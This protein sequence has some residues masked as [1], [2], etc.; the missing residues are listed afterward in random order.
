M[1]SKSDELSQNVSSL[2][3]IGPKTRDL[4]NQLGIYSIFDLLTTIPNSLSDKREAEL[5]SQ[6]D[7]GDNVVLSGE[8]INTSRTKGYKPNYIL[9]VRSDTGIFN[10]RFI[11]KIVVF[12]NLQVGMS[13][14]IEGKAIKKSTKLEFIHPEIEII[15]TNKSLA[16]ILPKYSTKGKISQ[17][18][19]R[20]AIHEAFIRLSKNYEFTCLDILFN[21]DFNFMS[22]L[23]AVKKLH[24]PDGDFDDADGAPI[25]AL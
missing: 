5:L 11:H 18:K 15:Q 1:R 19:M 3:G 8:I 12:L 13:I 20:K 21:N 9:T 6:I 4:F 22:L 24:Y 2:K 16:T 14:R 7:D 23:K 10:V 17:Q 25:G